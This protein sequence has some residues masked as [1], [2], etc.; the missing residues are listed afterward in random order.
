MSQN[1]TLFQITSSWQ[2]NKVSLSYLSFSRCSY[3]NH[4]PPP[5]ARTLQFMNDYTLYL[6]KCSTSWAIM[7][8]CS[9]EDGIMLG[10]F[11]QSIVITIHNHIISYHITSRFFSKRKIFVNIM[12]FQVFWCT[13]SRREDQKVIFVDLTTWMHSFE[14]AW[15]PTFR[16]W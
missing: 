6:M 2:K 8:N 11:H 7:R 14:H 9:L 16:L 12:S 1:R 3:Q 13:N 4:R 10:T 15:V 5:K